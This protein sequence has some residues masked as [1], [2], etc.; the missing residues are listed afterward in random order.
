MDAS[1]IRI[2]IQRLGD[3]N[4]GHHFLLFRIDDNELVGVGIQEIDKRMFILK[5]TE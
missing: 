1:G 3:L 4:V 2:V 5:Q